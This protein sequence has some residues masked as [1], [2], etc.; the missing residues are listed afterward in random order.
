MKI[1]NKCEENTYLIIS[2]LMTMRMSFRLCN[3]SDWGAVDEE[4][5]MNSY[6]KTKY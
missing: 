1:H 2:M 5:D 4:N 3:F 6:T